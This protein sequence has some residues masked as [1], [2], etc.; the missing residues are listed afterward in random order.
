MQNNEMRVGKKVYFWAKAFDAETPTLLSGIIIGGVKEESTIYGYVFQ[1]EAKGVQYFRH[2][3]NC[4][5]SFEA[6]REAL[7]GYL[8]E[9]AK[10]E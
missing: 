4:Y 2:A 1:I 5:P 6:V 3:W 9:G 7:E 10:D 8:I